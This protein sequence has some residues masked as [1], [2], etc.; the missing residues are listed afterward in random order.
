MSNDAANKLGLVGATSYVAGSIVGAGIFVS[1]RT[2]L[3][4]SGSVGMSLICWLAGA[5]ISTMTALLYIE[6]ATSIPL[7]G[8][9]FAYQNYVGWTPLAFSFLWLT[10]LIQSSCV[11]AILMRTFGEYLVDALEGISFE[12]PEDSKLLLERLLGFSLLWL[13][14]WANFFSIKGW[15]A[16]IQVVV[17]GAK[18]LAL[19][20][21]TL[22]GFY[23]LAFKGCT[24]QFSA[25]NIW[26]GSKTDPGNLALALY[27]GIWSYGGF[28]TLNYGTEDIDQAQIRR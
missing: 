21:I 15:A 28:D 9:D 20:I 23:Y 25:D 10:N 8:S 7:S 5:A 1:P 19:A 6:L 27:A 26:T 11:C 14:I 2:V 16:K 12:F 4:H 13:L 17:T 22:T 18:L 24:Q 3:E